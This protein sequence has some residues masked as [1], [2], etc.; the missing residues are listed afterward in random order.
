[1]VISYQYVIQNVQTGDYK[2]SSSWD[3]NVSNAQTF[4][5]PEECKTVMDTLNVGYYVMRYIG[6]IS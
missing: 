1:M 3:S 4:S 6:I 5:N 2:T